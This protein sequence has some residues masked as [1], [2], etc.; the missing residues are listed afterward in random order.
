M[1][2]VQQAM[3]EMADTMAASC[4]FACVDALSHLMPDFSK[5]PIIQFE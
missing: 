3:I 5:F 4:Q 1:G 2:F